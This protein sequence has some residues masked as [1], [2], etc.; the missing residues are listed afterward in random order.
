M[1]AALAAPPA[2]VP[3]GRAMTG[4]RKIAAIHVADG[5]KSLEFMPD[6][7]HV[8]TNNLYGN[9]TQ[10]IEAA[11]GRIVRNMA[12]KG[13]PVEAAFR[14]GGKEAWVSLYDKNAV[15]VI[16]TETGG[17]EA[18][19]K[20]GV[21]P[22]VVTVSPD[23]RFV[24]TANWRPSG[25][26]YTVSVIDAASR[27]RVH[28]I[29]IPAT[30]RGIAFTPNGKHAYVAVMGGS[31]LTKIDVEVGHKVL[32]H[33]GVGSNPRHVVADRTGRVLYVS[34][35]AAGR[36]VKYATDGDKVLGSVRTGAQPRTIELSADERYLFVCNN[37]DNSLSAVDTSTM[38]EVFKVRTGHHP[39]GVA[40]APD[41]RRVWVA[42][43]AASTLWVY[44]AIYEGEEFSKDGKGQ[45]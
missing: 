42:N 38:K 29:A 15:L 3:P 31:E 45:D 34:L 25:G 16:D 18:T 40:A 32:G 36:V 6:G 27:T 30:P 10:M 22:K 17:L 19:I 28:D 33:Y 1:A 5:P 23:G 13:E 4:L 7:R 9:A 2:P 26:R 44:D 43:Y 21:I 39:I 20:V 41:G 11:S 8:W 24:Y 14:N 12:W 37:K 35:N